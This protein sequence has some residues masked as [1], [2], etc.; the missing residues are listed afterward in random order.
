MDYRITLPQSGDAV[1]NLRQS[2]SESKALPVIL[3]VG[4]DRVV[5][6]SFGPLTGTYLTERYA[7]RAFVYGTL[8][9]PVHALNLTAAADLI[10]RRHPNAFVLAVDAALGEQ[11]NVGRILLLNHGVKAGSARNLDL[12][13]VG[14]MAVTATVC[15]LGNTPRTKLGFV[16]S[17][18][19]AAAQLI[20]GAL[21]SLT[22]P[23]RNC[24]INIEQR[25]NK[26]INRTLKLH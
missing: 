3:C 24:T 9:Y 20:A 12:P 4:S 19:A 5:Y 14:D 22:A 16:R 2:F 25:D 17:L 13:T 1:N 6:D 8:R 26:P 11:Q 21:S 23:S 15:S 18:S 10:E 7:V